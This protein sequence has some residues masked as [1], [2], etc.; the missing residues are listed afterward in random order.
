MAFPAI[1]PLISALL[2]TS[3]GSAAAGS[4]GG[5]SV[6]AGTAGATG[7]AGAAGA[8][9]MAGATGAA[10]MAGMGGAA[11]MAGAA[12]PAGAAGSPGAAG[13]TQAILGAGGGG[14]AGIGGDGGFG[15]SP[16]M[17]DLVGGLDDFHGTLLRSIQ[18]LERLYDGLELAES[19]LTSFSAKSVDILRSPASTVFGT[20]ETSIDQTISGK[21]LP[22]AGLQRGVD[23]AW[24]MSGMGF[25]EKIPII[26]I[27]PSMIKD[28]VDAMINLPNAI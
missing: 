7:A 8:A 15:S 28:V 22:T 11:G 21:G 25:L 13:V 12:G 27:L 3:A 2:G 6:G 1:G 16:S 19:A 14:A 20:L 5:A 26:G 4:V 23:A 17:Q 18:G 9:G 24:S 10:G